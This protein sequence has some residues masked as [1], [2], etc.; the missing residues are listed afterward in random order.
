[1]SSNEEHMARMNRSGQRGGAVGRKPTVC[2]R[3][4]LELEREGSAF[5]HEAVFDFG[6][7]KWALQTALLEGEEWEDVTPYDVGANSHGTTLEDMARADY[8]LL[9]NVLNVQ[10]TARDVV[11]LLATIGEHVKSNA[12]LICNL[13]REPRYGNVET[14][15]VG[16]GLVEA[17]FDIIHRS[18]YGSGTIWMARA[19]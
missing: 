3:K 2:T 5:R 19:L 17:G 9:S 16:L 1:M 6:A 13:P 4:L 11:E 14:A 7:G 8:V 15:H 10:A 12:I 18:Q